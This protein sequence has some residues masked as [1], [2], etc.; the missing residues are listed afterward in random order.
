MER[1]GRWGKLGELICVSH[2]NVNMCHSVSAMCVH[3]NVCGTA[4]NHRHSY[5]S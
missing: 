5:K 3:V 4:A 2:V 1:R